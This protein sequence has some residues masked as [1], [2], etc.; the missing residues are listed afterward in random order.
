MAV[1]DPIHA[2]PT[3]DVENVPTPLE[4]YDMFASDPGLRDAV[5]RE[6][7]AWVAERCAPLGARLGSAEVLAWGHDANRHPPELH[8]FDRF[9]R[10]ID[11]VEFHPAYHALMKLAIEAR[12]PTIAWAEPKPGAHLAHAAMAYMFTQAEAGV[13]CPMAMT[14]A[15]VPALRAQ[16]DVAAEWEPRILTGKY[17][18][19][20]IPA[21][22]KAGVTF[23]MAMT[24]KQGGSDVR[25]NT[26]RARPI[27]KAGAGEEYLL[28]GH[29]WFC[30][31]PMSDGFLTLAQAERGLSCFLVPRFRPDGTRNNFFIQRLKDKLGNRSNASSEIEYV[32]TWARMVG[33]EGRGVQTIIEMVHHTRIGAA[34]APAGMMRHAVVQAVYHCSQRRAFG[35]RLVDQPLMRAVLADLVVEVEAAT[36]LVMRIARAFDEGS[37]GDATARAFAR[38]ATAVAKYWTNKRAPGHIVEALECLGGAGYIEESPMPRLYREAPLNGIWEGSGNVIC[39]D[40]LRT[41]QREPAALGPV[42]EELRPAAQERREIAAMLGRIETLLRGPDLEVRARELVQCMA[43]VLQ[44]ALL[45]KHGE[46]AIADAFCRTRL[47]DAPP[48]I[49]GTLPPD[50][51]T[52]A[53]VA[54]AQPWPD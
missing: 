36:I 42:L 48:A 45:V 35:K 5:I 3:H 43:V 6:G 13:L 38:L 2:L 14:Y 47:G 11:E 44:A 22:E 51:A 54:R 39:L 20:C 40:V 21:A 50:V 28:T 18:P 10:R 12:I 31:A 29:K 34:V 17:D 8:T 53:I 1:R 19:R 15:V 49:Y 52:A 32:D 25:A 7:G 41:L 46:P 26:T 23:G 30:S 4:D 16:P 9:G 37:R 27:G 33:D 24:E